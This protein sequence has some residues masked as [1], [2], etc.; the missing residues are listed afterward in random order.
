MCVRQRQ[1][2]GHVPTVR[3]RIAFLSYSWRYLICLHWVYITCNSLSH[4]MCAMMVTTVASNRCVCVFIFCSWFYA[5][6]CDSKAI[7]WELSRVAKLFFSLLS[8][9]TSTSPRQNKTKLD[10]VL[11][12][13]TIYDW[14]ASN[15]LQ[16]IVS[17]SVRIAYQERENVV[18]IIKLFNEHTL[19]ASILIGMNEWHIA[20]DLSNLW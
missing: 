8:T 1:K 16:Y 12:I 20:I 11:P 4:I 13:S 6:R 18:I 19:L 3:S 7:L 5:H 2:Q 9:S 17:I 10:S 14:Y 15:F